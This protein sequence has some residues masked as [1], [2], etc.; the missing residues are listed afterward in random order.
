MRHS[1]LFFMVLL[2]VASCNSKKEVATAE[3]TVAPDDRN[4]REYRYMIGG[5]TGTI[6][7]FTEYQFKIVFRGNN[8][9]K[10]PF[11]RDFRAIAMA[12]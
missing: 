2:F 5:D 8:S 1:I 4:F 9:S 7:A 10:V 3:T 11:I 12:T 6:D